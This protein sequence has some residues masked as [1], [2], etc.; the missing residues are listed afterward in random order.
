MKGLTRKTV[1]VLFADVVDSTG[2]GEAVDPEAVRELMARYFNEMRAV[3]ERHGGVVEKYIGDEIMAVFGIPQVHEDDAVRAVRAATEMRDVLGKLNATLSHELRARTALNTGEVVAG[4]DHTLVTGDAVNTAARLRSVTSPGEIIVGATTYNLVRDAV[5]AEPL[6][7]LELRGKATRVDAWRITA[8]LPDA[9]G[10]AR[11]LDSELVGREYELALLR[12]SYT[13]A[14]ASRSC[15]LATILGPA[16]VGKSRLLHELLVEVHDDASTLVGRCLPYGDGITFW[17]LREIVHAVG[18]LRPLIDDDDA[19]AVDSALG[20]GGNASNEEI[21]RAFRRL[22]E[23]LARQYPLV[24]GFDDV[25][26]ADATFLDLV[27]HLAESLQDAPVLI[28]CL[29]RPDLLEDRPSWGGGKLNATTMLL[30]ALDAAQSEQLL[31]N[32]GGGTLAP[33]LRQTIT[34]VAEGNP[35]FLEEMLQ[36]AR[37]DPQAATVPPTIHALLTARLE[38]LDPTERHVVGCAAVTG[39]LFSRDALAALAATEELDSVLRSLERKELIRPHRVSFTSGAAYRFRHIL[40]RDAAYDLLPKRDRARMHRQLAD[41]L[42]VNGRDVDELVGWHL[43]CAFRLLEDLAEVDADVAARAAAA[44]ARAGHRALARGDAGAARSLLQ[45]TVALSTPV[46]ADRVERLLDFAAALQERGELIEAEQAL[47]EAVAAARALGDPALEARSLVERSFV[48]FYTDPHQWVGEALETAEGAIAV[49]E[50]TGDDF[51]LARAWLLVLLLHYGRCRVAEMENALEP[52]LRYARRATDGRQVAVALSASVRAL[53]IGPKPVDQAVVRAKAVAEE[54]EAD[55]ALA[56]VVCGVVAC[57]D[58]MR[59]RFAEA[60][61]SC[62]ESNAA[63]E[64]LGRTRLQAAQRAYSGLVELLAGD[65]AAAEQELR[66]GIVEL[67]RIGDKT[68]LATVAGLLAEA[69]W[70]QG[71]W[72]DAEAATELSKRAASSADVAAHVSWRLTRARLEARD[73]RFR[74][75]GAFAD[76]AVAL[77]EATD[78]PTLLADALLC[79]GETAAAAGLVAEAT[80]ALSSAAERYERKGHLV[81]AARARAALDQLEVAIPSRAAVASSSDG[82]DDGGT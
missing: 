38:R 82:G 4:D 23:A 68:N 56:A 28:A 9:P 13:R 63:L 40:I 32:L 1:T 10:R 34:E 37:E 50:E 39:R 72:T 42:E 49:L 53:L 75:A 17:P 31:D 24:L 77:A 66:R 64:D 81:G 12:Q 79:R 71:R 25:Q 2:L 51:G 55:R 69:L 27:E 36:L 41:W 73:E 65:P 58:A 11:R 48:S 33:S 18:D 44:L 57:L 59:G 47:R 80:R 3:V 7:P 52:A 26:W 22:V 6:E 70:A 45:R 35:L 62:A 20:R 43:E 29:A 30:E 54:P 78:S 74:E 21:F 14:A 16:G 76:E 67:E 15:H 60:R 61:A 46:D 19:R 8:T 5:L